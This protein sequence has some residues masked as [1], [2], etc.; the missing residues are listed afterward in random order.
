MTI[1]ILSINKLHPSAL[2]ILPST[3]PPPPSSPPSKPQQNIQ[4]I[5]DEPP[6]A[7]PPSSSTDLAKSTFVST[8]S[9]DFTHHLAAPTAT[10]KGDARFVVGDHGGNVACVEVKGGVV[11]EDGKG[12]KEIGGLQVADKILAMKLM[13]NAL[14]ETC[15]ALGCKDLVIRVVKSD[16]IIL[17]IP[18]TS[19]P[20]ALYALPAIPTSPSFFSLL[21]G[22]S[23]GH[24]HHHL[25]TLNPP[26][27]TSIFE[28]ST[29]A[30]NSPISITS[31]DCFDNAFVV[32]RSDGV[33]QGYVGWV[34]PVLGVEMEV[35][36]HV[37]N[38][39]GCDGGAV[40]V[41]IEDGRVVVVPFS[42]GK[43]RDKDGKNDEPVVKPLRP[44]R[45]VLPPLALKGG[46]IGEIKGSLPAIKGVEDANKDMKPPK[47][48]MV[49]NMPAKVENAEF[50]LMHG[51]VFEDRFD[52]PSSEDLDVV[53][54]ET[55][56]PCAIWKNDK[57][58][59]FDRSGDDENPFTCY[60]K[61]DSKS[62]RNV[63][64]LSILEGHSTILNLTLVTPE[65]TVSHRKIPIKPLLLHE[66]S[67]ATIEK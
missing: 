42:L 26:K 9:V 45:T 51:I 7:S 14:S 41:G 23:S 13:R 38:L 60:F 6:P 49:A 24:I 44:I 28:I 43:G 47:K 57:L 19:S 25:F 61:C 66:R 15:V 58:V 40:V 12:W 48:V 30:Q 52:L 8:E 46:K 18:M 10:A 37:T 27:S 54:M 67:H 55:S 36:G 50:L 3:P 17:T 53:F 56:I 21:V 16:Q 22:L 34:E 62:S 20:T 64:K 2:L 63:L 4:D 32:G 33:V 1:S 5:D 59:P 65:L 29:H 11:K 35:G 31:L 39:G